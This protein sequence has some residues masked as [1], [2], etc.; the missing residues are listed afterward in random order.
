[1]QL[2]PLIKNILPYIIVKKMT[3]SSPANTLFIL[4]LVEDYLADELM[5]TPCEDTNELFHLF[6][7]L[8]C[9]LQFSSIPSSVKRRIEDHKYLRICPSI[10]R[11][12]VRIEIPLDSLSFSRSCV[13]CLY[14]LAVNIFHDLSRPGG[15][16]IR[17]GPFLY[18]L[19]VAR[20][21]VCED[22][23]I[24]QFQKHITQIIKYS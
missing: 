1:M 19:P 11:I 14:I 3:I 8:R 17:Y 23:Q 22:C 24:R 2:V 6:S 12:C 15:P 10:R 16:T 13:S 7:T 21:I 9:V 5:D 4:S 20:K 18:I